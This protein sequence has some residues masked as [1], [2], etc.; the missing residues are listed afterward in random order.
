MLFGLV[1]VGFNQAARIA[2]CVGQSQMIQIQFG[3]LRFKAREILEKEIDDL[4]VEM[5]PGTAQQQRPGLVARHPA[6]IGAVFTHR[7]EAIYD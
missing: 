2:L 3:N 7:V 4:R 1:D 6:T 5:R